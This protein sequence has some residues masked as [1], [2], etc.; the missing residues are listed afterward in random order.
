MTV[1]DIETG[2]EL[3][4]RRAGEFAPADFVCPNL[5]EGELIASI[6]S[7]VQVNL[8]D[9]VG[10][11]NLTLGAQNH[12]GVKTVQVWISGGTE[13]E[14]YCITV[15]LTSS[16]GAIRTASGVVSVKAVC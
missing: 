12:D 6:N 5:T 16:T 7:V 3:I 2:L 15:T 4:V 8:G 10:S 13:G 14:R 11:A 9:V 1:L